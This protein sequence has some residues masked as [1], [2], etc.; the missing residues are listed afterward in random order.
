MNDTGQHWRS[1]WEAYAEAF[2]QP[3]QANGLVS[4][5]VTN[6]NVTGC[7]AESWI[8]STARNM[9]G[10]SLRISTGAVIRSSD[11]GRGLDKVP[12]CDLIIWD[13]SELPGLFEQGDFALVPLAAVRGL[14]EI[15]RTLSSEEDF[16]EQLHARGRLVPTGFLLGVVVSHSGTL[17]DFEC[18]TNWFAERQRTPAGAKAPP[19][20]RL[21]DAA[22]QPDT[23]GVLA[24]I[25][26]L[27]QIAGHNRAVVA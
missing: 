13:P 3:L 17:R 20:T 12:Q 5:F 11:T 7:Y 26:F 8:R 10:G 19:K 16:T 2:A 4:R 9:L 15:K 24:F 18:T 22:N 27:A 1:H 23:N 14:I 6:R 25:Y 21:L